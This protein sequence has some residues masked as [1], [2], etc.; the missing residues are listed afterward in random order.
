M[1]DTTFVDQS[2]LIPSTWLND[3]NIAVYRALG[4]AGVAP[5]TAAQV[6]AN[7]NLP[8][9]PRLADGTTPANGLGMSGF[10]FGT[11]YPAGTAGAE[12]QVKPTIVASI[13]ALRA[14]PKSG[15]PTAIPTSYYAG[16][17]PDGGGGV[18]FSLSLGDTSS[19]CLFT[20][21][22]ATGPVAPAAPALSQ[23][24]SGALAA[25][26]YFAK[27][28]YVT[29]AGETLA[30]AESSLSVLINNVLVV[31][32]PTATTGA[33]GYNVYVSTTTGTETKQNTTPINIGTS[34]QEPN[35]GLITGVVV[36]VSSTAGSILTAINVTNGNIS[37]GHR[38]S[39]VGG[40]AATNTYVVG[41]I[42]G[43][44]GTGTTAIVTNPGQTIASST[45]VTDNG[46]TTLV[47]FDGGRWKSTLQ[48]SETVNVLM[49]GAD[50]SGT[51]D[52]AFA[53]QS[54]VAS[55][56]GSIYIPS[57][58]YAMSIQ[59][60]VSSYQKLFGDG[61]KTILSKTT[62][63]VVSVTDPT[64]SVTTSNVNCIFYVDPS[65]VTNTDD[66]TGVDAA[67]QVDIS[68]MRFRFT[69]PFVAGSCSIFTTQLGRSRFSELYTAGADWTIW[70]LILYTTVLDRMMLRGCRIDKG[71][72]LTIQS[73]GG[74]K[75]NASGSA[76]GW[77]LNNV[78]YS[79]L[80]G[81]FTEN[82]TTAFR[83]DNCNLSLIAVGGE[84]N[85]GT[86]NIGQF[87]DIGNNNF[88]TITD[89]NPIVKS[90][91]ATG[92]I[93]S[94]SGVN[95]TVRF[96][97]GVWNGNPGQAGV[98][99]LY[100]ASAGNNIWFYDTQFYGGTQ[101]VINCNGALGRDSSNVY[102]LAGKLLTRYTTN[103]VSSP[104]LA[105]SQTVL[106][107]AT[108]NL[109]Q[110][111]RVSGGGTF[112]AIADVWQANGTDTFYTKKLGTAGGSGVSGAAVGGV[113]CLLDSG[114]GDASF[115]TLGTGKAWLIGN[116]G[117]VTLNFHLYPGA[118]NAQ[119]LGSSTNRWTTVYA[120]TGTIN[121]SDANTKRDIAPLSE[122]ETAVARDLK[123]LIRT[124]RLKESVSSKAGDARIHCGA[125]AQDVRDVF[126]GHG[127]DPARYALFCSDTWH[128]LDGE[129][130]APDTP[131]AIEV[132][133]LGLRY[134]EML[135][136]IIGAM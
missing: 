96:I 35:T 93:V 77:K 82:W 76:Y 38:L 79:A 95:N 71:T 28:T 25:T 54:A 34:W 74:Y 14:L 41:Y 119:T 125:I 104:L 92:A 106:D 132:T 83:F 99:D 109:I 94:C 78:V 26:T 111:K 24:T 42:T 30:S 91:G 120:T 107:S 50:P 67:S 122:T 85:A 27:V 105:S 123:S 84:V 12:L 1:T 126:L 48:P 124:F 29:A 97:G 32:S 19:G 100:V 118:D 72:S 117:R 11:A 17:T 8:T 133:R 62:N 81:V 33:T 90:A 134:D 53:I 15:N 57:G 51:A 3:I 66:P 61:L 70:A 113:D 110:N 13:A 46:G 80:V 68:R 89:S 64:T 108:A 2:T 73:G 114:A 58:I 7:L 130:A 39:D 63:S 69:A 65:Y 5:T 101:P 128:E 103:N 37:V 87:I 40:L 43:T 121:T 22:V 55:G 131:G 4:T 136:F 60:K 112:D 18:A 135:A 59:V 9:I 31:N 52:S 129:P 21:S 47:A 102:V 20:G 16:A 23:V 88:L 127:L 36:P 116:G 56:A 75:F 86:G 6:I 45:M 44:G 49:W 10:Q 115:G 98:Y